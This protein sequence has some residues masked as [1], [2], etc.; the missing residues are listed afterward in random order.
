MTYFKCALVGSGLVEVV[1]TLPSICNI[2]LKFL[3]I[4]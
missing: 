2:N 1:N 4:S 3:L